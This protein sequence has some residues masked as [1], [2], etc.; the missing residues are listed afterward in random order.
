[1]AQEH[2]AA[3]L[4]SVKT[5]PS[6]SDKHGETACVAGGTARSR[7]TRVGSPVPDEVPAGRL[8]PA[9]QDEIIEILVT[10]RADPRI[11]GRSRWLRSR[12]I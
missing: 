5:Y 9:V 8:G 7:I 2:V 3:V 4:V 1:M 11:R 12:A 10:P 6:P